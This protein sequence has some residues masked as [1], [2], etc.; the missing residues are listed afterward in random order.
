ML[1]SLCVK[2]WQHMR[3]RGMNKHFTA[4][5]VTGSTKTILILSI[6]LWPS[7]PSITFKLCKRR[8]PIKF[9]FPV[10]VSKA[11]CQTLKSV[12]IYPPSPVFPHGQLYVAFSRSSS[13]D[14]VAVAN[15]EGHRQRIENDRLISQT[16]YIEK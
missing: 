11:Q 8:F 2:W 4:A 12:A 14:N 9:A 15:I 13:F 16:L 5:E 7:D 1:A 6:Q 10:T 3:I